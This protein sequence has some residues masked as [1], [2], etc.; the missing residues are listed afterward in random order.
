MVGS[1]FKCHLCPSPE[2]LCDQGVSGQIPGRA[3]MRT[4]EDHLL[5]L[6]IPHAPTSG[7]LHLLSPHLECSSFMRT[8]GV[9]LPQPAAARSPS[10]P[11]ASPAPSTPSRPSAS[12]LQSAQPMASQGA[13]RAT[14]PT[15]N[16]GGPL[17]GQPPGIG[18]PPV[19]P[20][21]ARLLF[22]RAA[23]SLQAPTPKPAGRQ[24]SSPHLGQVMPSPFPCAL[25]PRPA[26]V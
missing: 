14:H 19:A 23:P 25:R 1:A 17:G 11:E 20:A 4:Q 13:S 24:P 26:W 10:P 15:A 9:P 21:P 6:N 3:A 16:C 12:P 5:F 7:S 2:F 18:Q 22:V 8:Q